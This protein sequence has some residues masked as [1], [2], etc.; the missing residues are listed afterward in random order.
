MNFELTFGNSSWLWALLLLL[1]LGWLFYYAQQ[2]RRE[3]LSRLIAPRLQQALSV[4]VSQGK[5][6]MRV[7]FLLLALGLLIVAL[8][9]PRLGYSEQK[10]TT[11]G[12]DIILAIDTSRS[13]LATDVAPTRLERAKLLAQDVMDLLPGDR[14]GLIAFAG[15]AFL[16][17]PMTL[18]HN[19]VRT[20]LSEL[21]TNLIPKGGTNIAE[22]IRTAVTAFGKGEGTSRALIIMTDGEDL[23]PD[24]V[25]EAK[26]AGSLG[27]KIFTIGIGSEEGSLIPI[28]NERGQSDFVRD[29][30]GKPVLS[31]L[32]VA[33]LKEMA[34]MTG[35]FY[36]PFGPE[37]ARA[38]VN[39]GILSLE[40]GTTGDLTARR[41]IERYEWPVGGAVVLLV[42]WTLL[43]ERRRNRRINVSSN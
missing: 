8:A 38:I 14:V 36:E 32:D 10:I 21:D 23:E 27:I 35:G 26:A 19:A 12:R 24:A 15:N 5:R 25:A 6:R 4:Q 18:D 31:K 28:K 17:A 20:S 30:T 29:E 3:L 11:H 33:R 13:M 42:F 7:V 43:S 2:Q 40:A 37:A 16:Q 22:A 1:P 39:K 34:Q 9:R 41:P